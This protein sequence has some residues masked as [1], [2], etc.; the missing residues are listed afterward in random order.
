MRIAAMSKQ[1]IFKNDSFNN[2]VFMK[3]A[4]EPL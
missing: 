3:H 1:Q 4:L 2:Q